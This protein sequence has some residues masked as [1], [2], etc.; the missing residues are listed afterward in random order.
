MALLIVAAA[1]AAAQT[2]TPS[3]AARDPMADLVLAADELAADAEKGTTLDE[4]QLLPAAPD[5]SLRATFTTQI[6]EAPIPF[7]AVVP[8]WTGDAADRIELRVRTGPDGRTWGDWIAVHANQDWMEPGEAEIVGEMVLVL[9]LIHIWLVEHPAGWDVTVEADDPAAVGPEGA[10]ITDRHIVPVRAHVL[11]D[12]GW[13][14][15]LHSPRPYRA[16]FTTRV[17]LDAGEYDLSLAYFADWRYD[18]GDAGLPPDQPD[19]ALVRLVVGR[20]DVAWT[21]PDPLR[22]NRLHHVIRLDEPTSLRLGFEVWSRYP[23][24]SNGFFLHAFT[25]KA[26]G[27][28]E[29]AGQYRVV[30]NLLP[31]DATLREKWHILFHTHAQRQALLQSH[32]DALTLV[33]RGR[34]DSFIRLWGRERL[35]DGQRAAIAGVGVQD[36]PLTGI[37]L[38]PLPPGGPEAL[39]GV[40]I[41]LLPQDATLMQ[42]WHVLQVVHDGKQSLMQ[43][44][45]DAYTLLELAGAGAL[46]R[47]WGGAGFLPEQTQR[48]LS[49]GVTLAQE[50]YPCLLYTSRCV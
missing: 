46:A 24:T 44:H 11:G 36:E 29:A 1:P 18:F 5:S 19:H 42:K 35:S 32:D 23:A 25:V 47:L 49:L 38:Q 20:R 2:G 28:L 33:R 50:S 10:F 16:R 14:Y 45:D 3:D 39:S 37:A 15:H 6:I 30:V 8:H 17:A 31:Q 13:A 12:D 9:S 34:A 40:V 4:N 48:L 22:H 27:G 7:N 21:T 26:R 41:N 43:S